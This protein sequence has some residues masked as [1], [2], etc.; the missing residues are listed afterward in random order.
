MTFFSDTM[1]KFRRQ[2]KLS[3]RNPEWVIISLI[4]PILYLAFFGPLLARIASG[5]AVPP[6]ARR[7]GRPAPPAG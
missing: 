1:L 5:P 6:P 3:L 2:L 4:Q 7:R